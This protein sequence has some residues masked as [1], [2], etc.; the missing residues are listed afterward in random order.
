M[1]LP[2]DVIPE[3]DAAG[4]KENIEFRIRILF[5]IGADIH[6]KISSGA[7][8]ISLRGR[9]LLHRFRLYIIVH[10]PLNIIILVGP[11]ALIDSGQIRLIRIRYRPQNII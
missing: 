4:R 1:I 7:L 11:P 2:H 8:K 6:I 9:L 10:D 5:N 3:Q